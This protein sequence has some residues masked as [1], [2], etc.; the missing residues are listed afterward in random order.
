M[1]II[2]NVIISV[3]SSTVTDDLFGAFG[4]KARDLRI[5]HIRTY[6]FR[7][8]KTTASGRYEINKSILMGNYV[9][10]K[11]FMSCHFFK[12]NVNV[13]Y[14]IDS[15][16]QSVSSCGCT[17]HLIEYSLT[18]TSECE[19]KLGKKEFEAAYDYLKRARFSEKRESADE[20]KIMK[21]LKQFVKDP[22]D[23]FMVDQLLFL[24]E[25]AKL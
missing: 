21:D 5:K 25:Q 16:L 13:T 10:F 8:K 2:S 24:E 4:P 15:N 9:F 12:P 19:K 7:I 11:C 1:H 18:V 6:P 23:C 14:S 17:L 3:K 22:S 20:A